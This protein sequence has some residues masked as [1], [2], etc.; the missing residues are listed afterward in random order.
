MVIMRSYERKELAKDILLCFVS[1]GVAAGLVFVFSALP[2][3]AYIFKLFDAKTSKEHARIRNAV[4][5]LER[6]GHVRVHK[7]NGKEYITITENGKKE[8]GR[9]KLIQRTIQKPKEWD[10][11]WRLVMF[12]IPEKNRGSRNAFRY[13]LEELGLYQYQKSV[14]IYPY[15]CKE[16][17]NFVANYFR[18]RN[19]ISYVVA[20]KVEAEVVLKRKFKL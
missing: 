8:A 1:V 2:G 12:D 6:Q 20:Q 7:K 3:L 9:F 18:I 4:E 10:G 5:R 14:F 13:L 17:V 15:E 16:E 19:K 11:L